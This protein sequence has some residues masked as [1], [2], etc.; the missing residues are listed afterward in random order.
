MA[1]R[2]I[3]PDRAAPHPLE[4]C[5]ALRRLMLGAGAAA[6][7]AGT[8]PASEALAQNYVAIENN[9]IQNV[10]ARDPA[11]H[12]TPN[13][14]IGADPLP[15]PQPAMDKNQFLSQ[16]REVTQATIDEGA[17]AP[18]VSLAATPGGAQVDGQDVP[19][20]A[21]VPPEP[22]DRLFPE[23]AL[24]IIAAD[25]AAQE[26]TEDGG[27]VEA[28]MVQPVPPE[29]GG[30]EPAENVVPDVFRP[31][32]VGTA[33]AYFSS[34][35]LVPTDARLEYPYR[36]NGKLFFEKPGGGSF[37]CSGAVIK[38]RLV[39]TAGH[40]VHQGSGGANGFYRRFLFVPAYHQGQA[41]YQAWNWTWVTTT[42]SW[43]NGGGGVPNQ[44]D[45]A[46]IEVEDRKFGT[47][48]KT[49]GEVVG[50]L[51]YRTGAL[52]PNHTK[53]VGYPGNHDSGQ[54]MHQVDSQHHLAA[55][56]NT[57]LFGSDMGG[58]SS[59]GAWIENFGVQAAGQ[60]GGLQPLPNRVVGV[61]SYGYISTDPKV[62][63]SSILNQEFLTLLNA[64]CQHRAGN[65]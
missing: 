25:V 35:R 22:D 32:D 10:I 52:M 65:C 46:I 15:L 16:A 12:W 18:A 56:Q 36:A 4:A 17:F 19:E 53:K 33:G 21:E 3:P 9:E 44:A 42:A 64:A 48:V 51:G 38:P 27:G 31:L 14:L 60:T 5:R 58:G 57:V 26:Q 39:L 20:A 34:S 29:E 23:S 8:A 11:G 2:N 59:G 1:K 47:Q 49:I 62:Q 50:S 61:T 63:G 24:P 28:P 30:A 37:I 41:P 54:I 13:T 6:L 7:L 45:F 43:A 40:C 55:P